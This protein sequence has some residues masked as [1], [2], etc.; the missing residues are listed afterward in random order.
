MRIAARPAAVLLSVFVSIFA[1]S[2]AA[3]DL[4]GIDWKVASPFPQ[5]REH[6]G[7]DSAWRTPR[8]R[9]AQPGA[10][11]VLPLPEEQAPTAEAWA[12][13][14]A[15]LAAP[16]ESPYAE[17]IG[18]RRDVWDEAKQ[19]YDPD[20]LDYIRSDRVW[21]SLSVPAGVARP[22]ACVWEIGDGERRADPA[23]RGI[24]LKLG[25][26]EPTAVT[27][28]DG[29]RAIARSS[30]Q[31]RRM[32]VLALGDSYAS[33]EGNPDVPTHWRDDIV[34]PDVPY[35]RADNLD[36][37][38]LDASNGNRHVLGPA[39]WRDHNCHRSFWNQQN[40]AAMRLAAEDPQREVAFLQFSC[41]GA[42]VLDGLMV[43]Q[44][45]P[46]GIGVENKSGCGLEFD[47]RCRIAY[48]Q[49]AAATMA[50]CHEQPKPL[51]RRH[52]QSLKDKIR[53]HGPQHWDKLNAYY[54]KGRP[55]EAPYGLD[56]LTC[57]SPREPDL[58]LLSLGGNDAGFANLVAWALM[59]Y[60][61]RYWRLSDDWNLFNA[62]RSLAVIC[63]DQD[64][65]WVGCSGRRAGAYAQQLPLRFGVFGS[66]LKSSRLVSQPHRVVLS[67]YPD[68][69]RMRPDPDGGEALLCADR[70]GQPSPWYA[71][72]QFLPT[73]ARSS[74]NW[75][76]A[77]RN[78]GE[79]R[80]NRAPE[81]LTAHVLP[82]IRKALR[83]SAQ[84]QGYTYVEK[85]ET[86]FAGRSWCDENEQERNRL[87]LPSDPRTA[88]KGSP[89]SWR[90]YAPRARAIRTA[91]DSY[92]T[93]LSQRSGDKNGAMHPTAEGHM[94]LAAQVYAAAADALAREKIAD[95]RP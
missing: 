56:L 5:Y 4:P 16:G 41:S 1:A 51:D 28:H 88:W 75:E 15:R 79:G 67:S 40:F 23:C 76:F 3:Q 37:L 82:G 29:D 49:L 66:A 21:V 84:A 19:R 50:L 92:M 25:S 18:T 42:E 70:S 90:P 13:W 35:G 27:L 9:G 30:V 8:V 86:A 32:V 6:A 17:F 46:P 43:R 45:N 62:F 14:Y 63:P 12:R 77:L 69:L 71:L 55:H 93:Q 80:N 48:S 52:L 47:P 81:V 87:G 36:W 91:N 11:S 7:R 85:I 95:S 57:D 73:V 65:T 74:G 72:N 39:R 59:P 33:G 89:A 24:E 60:Q 31:P 58:V 83:A 94:L 78:S 38:S 34:A 61:P 44:L 53:R 64:K 54:R 22:A 26:R 68:P 20:F 2:V 10:D